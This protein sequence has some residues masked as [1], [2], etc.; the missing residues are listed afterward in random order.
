[1]VSNVHKT[2]A[3]VL[4]TFGLWEEMKELA[5]S[6]LN[7]NFHSIQK[8]CFV[9]ARSLECTARVAPVAQLPGAKEQTVLT[10]SFSDNT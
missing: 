7:L 4:D 10:Q 3:D 2:V 9:N 1:M 6:Q 5:D 8:T